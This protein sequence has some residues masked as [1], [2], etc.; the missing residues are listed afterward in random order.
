MAR[1][2]EQSDERLAD[3]ADQSRDGKEQSDFR[4]T[5]CEV[6]AQIRQDRALQSVNQFV[7]KLDAVE[8]DDGK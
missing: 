2:G 8:D 1:V 4:I 3:D 6:V 5:Q 7:E